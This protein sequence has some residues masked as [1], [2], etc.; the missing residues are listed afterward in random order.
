[1]NPLESSPHSLFIQR[2]F[3]L[4]LHGAGNVAPNPLVGAVVVHQGKIIGEGYHAIFGGAHAEV[5]AINSVS[6][7][8][9]ALLP[10][11]TLYINLEPCCHFGKTPPCTDLIIQTGIRKIVFSNQDPNPVSS[12]G[13]ALLKSVGCEVITGI[14]EQQG[15][16]LNRRFFTRIKKK[17][18]YIILKWA[19][20]ADGFF[21]R[22]ANEQH[23]ITGE[24]SKRLAHRWRSEEAAILCGTNTVAVDN[25]QLTNRLWM[26]GKQPLRVVLDRTLRLPS[27]LHV[28]DATTPTVVFTEKQQADAANVRYAQIAFD[29]NVLNTVLQSLFEMGILSV[30]VEG[31]A[32]LLNNFISEQLWDEARIF[33]GNDF[34]AEGLHAPTIKGKII[35]EE[36]IGNDTLKILPRYQPTTDP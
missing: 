33:I 2:C 4:A 8:N 9:K 21:T 36:K 32:T 24:Q 15:A 12:G 13:A 18:P 22:N 26:Q 20:S 35:A 3:D 25:P 31:G 17:R 7:E 27:T 14:L 11:S 1:M 30:L 16:W 28:F 29:K 6:A 34:F 19:Q 5:N 23:W 10:H